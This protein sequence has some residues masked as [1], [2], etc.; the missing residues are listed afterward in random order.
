[1]RPLL[2]ASLLCAGAVAC[3]SAGSGDA[4]CMSNFDCTTNP[5]YPCRFGVTACMPVVACLDDANV[6]AGTTCGTDQVCN[7]TGKCVACAAGVL[8]TTN[9]GGICHIGMTTCA[10]GGMACI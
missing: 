2:A 6:A 5:S 1:M 9:P 3:S 4:G 10:G 8:C 7:G